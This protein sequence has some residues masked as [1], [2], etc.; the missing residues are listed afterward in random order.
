MEEKE[1]EILIKKNMKE[2]NIEIEEKEI[3]K[4][5]KYMNILIEWNKM[6]NLTAII[7]P[8]EII[9]KHFIDSITIEKHI[10]KNAKV[11]DIGTG[12]GFPGIPIKI[13][14]EDLDITLLDSLNKRVKFL[15]KVVK[16]IELKKIKNIHA[17]AE[18]YANLKE[19]R[20][21]YDFV[22]S[23]AVANLAVLAEYTL[24]FLKIDGIAVLM[25]G[26]EID[27]ELEEAKKAIEILGGEI[28]NIEE[29][30][31]PGSDFKRKNIIIR[32]IANTPNIYP[33][34]AG[35]AKKEPIK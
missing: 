24:P 34:K 5:Y 33:R 1:F 8:K 19:E 15:E 10:K 25:K 3:E 7:K 21:R 20:E 26:F 23:R 2:L 30:V 16:E 32:K 14:R 29:I 27:D 13:L 28:K 12:A 9:I 31:L 22:T 35:M 4:F 18:E 17:R 6:F 11:I